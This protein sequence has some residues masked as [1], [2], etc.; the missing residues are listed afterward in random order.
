[1]PRSGRVLRFAT[2][3]LDTAQAGTAVV[4]SRHAYEANEGEFA[5]AW[6]KEKVP[7]LADIF[8]K[9]SKAEKEKMRQNIG[10][11]GACPDCG[12]MSDSTQ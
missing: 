3:T 8:T 5:K 10:K 7:D 2:V 4:H 1:V 6:G 11:P 12:S 9:V